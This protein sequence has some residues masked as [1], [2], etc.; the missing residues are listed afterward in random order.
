MAE[1]Q[2][3]PL[4]LLADGDDELKKEQEKERELAEQSALRAIFQQEEPVLKENGKPINDADYD[5]APPSTIIAP[6]TGA[7]SGSILYGG[8]PASQPGYF[9]NRFQPQSP[10]LRSLP[11]G[12]N[13]SPKFP[14]Y[15]EMKYS[16][17]QP[18]AGQAFNEH[19]ASEWAKTHNGGRWQNGKI[20]YGQCLMYVADALRAGGLNIRGGL[21]D[22][23]ADGHWAADVSGAL[24]HD[25]R[26]Q[27]V[28]SGL[29]N[30]SGPFAAKEGDVAVW[31]GTSDH[32]VGHIMLCIGVR[33]NGSP[34]WKCDFEAR[35]GNPTG[36]ANPETRG[37]VKI[38]R[39]Q[40]NLDL[41][42]NKAP[43]AKAPNAASPAA[44]SPEGKAGEPDTTD[45]HPKAE[46]SKGDAPAI[47]ADAGAGPA[48]AAQAPPPAKKM[49][50]MGMGATA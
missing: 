6:D 46:P 35:E 29:G 19:A 39:Q 7:G 43:D 24:K 1:A 4:P 26:F 10:L 32:P 16:S 38:Y 34:I 22:R 5:P 31:E 15:P 36:L 47:K 11:G 23:G 45:T 37:V 13:Y 12:G 8:Q 41:A 27:V 50:G 40:R 33:A 44:K 25:P 2:T 21:P 18:G 20:H 14:N 49:A 17:D 28:A 9:P 30:V 48:K 3:Q 42:Q